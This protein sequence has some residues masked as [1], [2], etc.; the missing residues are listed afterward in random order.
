M[1]KLTI[2]ITILLSLIFAACGGNAESKKTEME[3]KT[4]PSTVSESAPANQQ[5]FSASNKVTPDAKD[6]DDLPANK[7]V[8]NIKAVKS[9]Q[10]GNKKTDADDARKKNDADDIGKSD[11]DNDDN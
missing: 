4:A 1:K 9:N 11:R 3:Q 10:S 7:Q 6:A 2:I 8:S 5:T